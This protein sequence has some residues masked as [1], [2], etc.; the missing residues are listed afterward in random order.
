MVKLND[1]LKASTL[2]EVIVGLVIIII[3]FGIVFKLL[4]NVNRSENLRLK[5]N[6]SLVMD[7]IINSSKQ[8]MNYID[9][10]IDYGYMHIEKSVAPYENNKNLKVI[11]LKAFDRNNK[12]ILEKKEIILEQP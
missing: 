9:D 6:A 11:H 12:L 2:I 7:E 8:Q 4:V 5:C 10:D 1:R 3:T